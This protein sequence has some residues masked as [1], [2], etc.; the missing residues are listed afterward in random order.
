MAARYELVE[1]FWIDDDELAGITAKQAFVLGVEWAL[2]RARVE[3]GEDFVQEIHAINA[4]RVMRLSG[5]RQRP[6]ECVLDERHP[7]WATLRVGEPPTSGGTRL[8]R[9][10]DE[11]VVHAAVSSAWRERV[12][13]THG[14]LLTAATRLID[15]R[16]LTLLSGVGHRPSPRVDRRPVGQ[17]SPPQAKTGRR[18]LPHALAPAPDNAER[19]RQ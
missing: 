4:A 12:P 5:L 16:L 10:C 18:S 2:V 6:V 8:P 17:P 14:N 3:S 1:P 11:R 9:R 15:P 19:I 13:F 7:G